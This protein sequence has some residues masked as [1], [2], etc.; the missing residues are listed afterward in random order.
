MRPF[1]NLLL[2]SLAACSTTLST[3]QPA[4]PMQPGH[5]QAQAALDGVVPVS[6]IGAAV[7]RVATLGAKYIDDPKYKP[8]TEEQRR[9]LAAG[10]G[11]G[12]SSPGVSPDIMVRVGVVKDLDVGF[13]YSGLAV[14]ADG[15][16]RFLTTSNPDHG[17]EGAISLGV[18]R[19][20]HSG[21]VFDAL[22]FLHVADYSRWN[23]EVPVIFG[24]RLGEY[25]HVWFGPKY[26]F[27]T[28]TLD[29]TL[30]NVGAISKTSG[31]IHHLGA[32]GG[33]AVGYKV[34]FVFAELTVMNMFANP[35]IFGQPT[36]LGG[37]VIAPSGGLMLRL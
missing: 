33:A 12:L 9:I 4:E 35:E 20:L 24:S 31:T 2:L 17:L 37:I 19:A 13:R 34:V 15:K 36:D 30:R 25:G 22:D 29:G 27:T 26:I 16:Y 7:D 23:V 14:H 18:S 3:L 32:F 8:T 21:L 10:V 1:V 11:L 28:Y 5:V 6:R